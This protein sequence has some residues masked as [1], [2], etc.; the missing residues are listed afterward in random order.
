MRGKCENEFILKE[1]SGLNASVAPLTGDFDQYLSE[2][3][4]R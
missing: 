3:K 4:M 2:L 1:Y